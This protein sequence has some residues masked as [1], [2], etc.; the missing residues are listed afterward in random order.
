MNGRK[1]LEFKHSNSHS[2]QINILMWENK[3]QSTDCSLVFWRHHNLWWSLR[4]NTA[5]RKVKKL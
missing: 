4:I 5:A 1:R 2:S 3:K